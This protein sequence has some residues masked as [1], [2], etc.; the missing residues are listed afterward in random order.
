MNHTPYSFKSSKRLKLFWLCHLGL[1]F[2]N[3]G[4]AQL[5][6]YPNKP[7]RMVVP[8]TPGG[9]TDILARSIGQKLSQSWNQSVIIDNVPGAGGSIG[10]DKVAK[11]APDGYT[12]LMSLHPCTP[13]Y[14]MTRSKALRQLHGSQKFPT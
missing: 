8:F 1:W 9:S 5:Q 2:A 4:F 7:I 11:S 10:A 12:I 14:P 13:I 6:P 3:A